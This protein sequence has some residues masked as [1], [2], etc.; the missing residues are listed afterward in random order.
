M[1]YL[2]NYSNIFWIISAFSC[3]LTILTKFLSSSFL[4]SSLSVLLVV[5]IRDD[6]WLSF[7]LSLLSKL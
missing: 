7:L 1:I 6:V 2:Y 4:L 5:V 3:S